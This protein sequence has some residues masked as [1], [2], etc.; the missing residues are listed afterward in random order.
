MML[1]L[2]AF[3]VFGYELT[4]ECGR[5]LR[6]L[7][8]FHIN[9]RIS[10][11]SS[12]GKCA[13]VTSECEVIYDTK[14]TRNEDPDSLATQ[15]L[16]EKMAELVKKFDDDLKFDVEQVGLG[17]TTYTKRTPDKAEQRV[18]EL[19]VRFQADYK[20]DVEALEVRVER[21]LDIVVEDILDRRAQYSERNAEVK[22][23][24]LK[25]IKD[26]VKIFFSGGVDAGSG[27]CFLCDSVI[28]ANDAWERMR[29]VW[30]ELDTHNEKLLREVKKVYDF[31]L[32]HEGSIDNEH[33]PKFYHE[34]LEKPLRALGMQL[35]RN[36][37]KQLE[38]ENDMEKAVRKLNATMKLVTDAAKEGA[39]PAKV[40]RL[41]GNIGALLK[42]HD[43][44]LKILAE[45]K[46][47]TDEGRKLYE[48][49][50]KSNPNINGKTWMKRFKEF[51]N[52]YDDKIKKFANAT[53][54]AAQLTWD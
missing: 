20:K 12:G 48:E 13:S 47:L 14:F 44:N 16:I 6:T 37:Q 8:D 23:S 28:G 50:L 19:L 54:D 2:M 7:L 51:W 39:D 21:E 40:T 32:R 27:V 24:L 30:R 53:A 31:N 38:V 18:A 34:G 43:S 29:I 3:P 10:C 4:W 5:D 49:A 41:E 45:A 9:S 17:I 15:Q 35:R 1:A 46:A 22:K 36:E 42:K 52:Q 25:V 11:G 26:A 33:P